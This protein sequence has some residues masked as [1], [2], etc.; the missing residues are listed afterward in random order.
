[1]LAAGCFGL[2]AALG[3]SACSAEEPTPAAKD[4]AAKTETAAPEQ[5]VA[6]AAPAPEAS[7]APKAPEQKV[8]EAAPAAPEAA[9]APA[10][11]EHSPAA[12]TNADTKKFV[13]GKWVLP[14]GEITFNVVGEGEGE[15]R[16]IKKVDWYTYSGWR[17]YHAE[18]HECHGPG[19][20]GSSFAP[21]LAESL[22]HMTY[23]KFLQVVASGQVRD[24]AGTKFIMPA[25]GDNP[26]VM[27]FIDDIYTYLKARASDDMP[28]G[29]LSADQRDEKPPQ[30]KEYEKSCLPE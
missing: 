4:Q 1:M 8:A 2:A 27:C 20:N 21:A 25:R 16:V 29:R 24:V 12:G 6:E 22:K 7:A 9:A 30:A 17:R 5:K 3:V 18:C 10:E 19:G 28:P 15:N 11:A 26:N 23:E 14:D 13:D